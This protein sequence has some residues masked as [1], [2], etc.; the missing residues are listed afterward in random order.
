MSFQN[1]IITYLNLK[2]MGL[3]KIRDKG[4]QNLCFVLGRFTGELEI[5]Y[6]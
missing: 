3:T 5:K 6:P 2:I 4:A 1:I